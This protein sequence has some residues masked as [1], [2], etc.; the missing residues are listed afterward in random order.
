MDEKLNKASSPD[1]NCNRLYRS[2]MGV[3]DRLSPNSERTPNDEKD[4][5]K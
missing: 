1:Q 5:T 4:A 3:G 2:D